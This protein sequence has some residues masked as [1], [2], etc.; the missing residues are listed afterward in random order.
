MDEFVAAKIKD[1]T[2]SL[3]KIKSAI[4][5]NSTLCGKISFLNT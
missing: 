4:S 5:S 2:E 3:K 1:A